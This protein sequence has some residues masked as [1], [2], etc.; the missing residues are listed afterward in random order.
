MQIT[1]VGR[2][3]PGRYRGWPAWILET[4]ECQV[5]LVPSL[6]GKIASLTAR[7]S[8]REFLAQPAADPVMP[9]GATPRFV[10]SDPFGFDDMFP[11]ILAGNTT[12]D[13]GEL[14]AFADHG[15]AWSREWR[16][17][18]EENAVVLTLDCHSVPFR[19]SKRC[20]MA[21][22][23][24]LYLDYTVTNLSNVGHDV[25]WAA[26]PLIAC[27]DAIRVELPPGE[28]VSV[29]DGS[30]LYGDR[31]M[32]SRWQPLVLPAALT[33]QPEAAHKFYCALQ[34]QVRETVIHF[35]GSGERLAL[36]F[37]SHEPA[38]FGLWHEERPDG[39][40]IIAP[41][42]CTGGFDRPDLARHH[43]QPS[44]FGPR[45]EKSWRIEI[46]IAGAAGT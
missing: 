39:A 36:R 38:Y 12:N 35:T 30:A 42:P 10:D 11:T 41:E 6:G 43:G 22:A 20:S 8:G 27:S 23:R 29:C 17:Q 3:L 7:R 9:A 46:E 33:G 32:R 1:A 44:H 5:I 13:A 28:V 25:L 14:L 34:D 24:T 31:G 16:A 2:I 19:I 45:Q 26:H 18:Q 21:D 4:G 40:R 37:V 15:E